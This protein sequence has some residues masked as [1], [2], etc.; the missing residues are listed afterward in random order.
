QDCGVIYLFA[1]ESGAL[2]DTLPNPDCDDDDAFRAVFAS[3]AVVIGRSEKLDDGT[4][5]GYR[6][7]IDGVL[8]PGEECDD[9]NLVDG[10]GC[11][12]SCRVT[13]C[14]NGTVT[15]G[16]QCDDGNQVAGDGCEPDCTWSPLACRYY[17]LDDA[18][19][20]VRGGGSRE[21]I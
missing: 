14:G 15:A 21:T 5:A 7:C 6:P 12:V 18:S 10:D 19:I 13:R 3:D 2:L 8:A 17:H 11:D 1:V 20:T 4:L 9:G 16:E